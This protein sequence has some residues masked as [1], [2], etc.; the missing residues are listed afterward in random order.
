MVHKAFAWRLEEDLKELQAQPTEGRALFR[1][2][3]AA[4]L[5]EELVLKRRL[6]NG[7]TD[8]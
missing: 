7:V 5:D 3:R 2:H 6:D 1:C 4:E 8:G